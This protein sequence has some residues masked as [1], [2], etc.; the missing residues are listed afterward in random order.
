MAESDADRRGSELP[1][2]GMGGAGSGLVGG[3]GRWGGTDYAT[4][5]MM[6]EGGSFGPGYGVGDFSGRG[7]R[8][9]RRADRRI[10]EEACEA[11]THHAGVDASD[12]AVTVREGEVTLEGTVASRAEKRM[13][14]DA[15]AD[16]RG[17]HDVQNRLRVRAG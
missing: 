11:L 10:E 13:A 9:Y 15:V 3:V 5:E 8:N 12:I 4:D 16:L 1:E 7:P 14:E 6:R 2:S 17:V